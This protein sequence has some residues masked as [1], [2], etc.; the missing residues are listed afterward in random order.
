MAAD[1][2]M[3]TICRQPLSDCR[4]SVE[5]IL[6]GERYAA[7]TALCGRAAPTPI[8]AC[9][10]RACL[11]KKSVIHAKYVLRFEP[12]WCCIHHNNH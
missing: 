8:P 1:K 12:Q 5:I 9:S 4:L 10:P 11:F 2:G 3:R 7:P 6:V